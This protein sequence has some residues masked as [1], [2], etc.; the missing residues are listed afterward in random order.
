MVN[1]EVTD[2]KD[3]YFTSLL[4]SPKGERIKGEMTNGKGLA[5]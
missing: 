1:H 2:A 3:V 5:R 4:R